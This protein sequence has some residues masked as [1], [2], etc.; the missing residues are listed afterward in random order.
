MALL[1]DVEIKEAIKNSEI[2]IDPFDER[3]LKGSS[4]DLRIGKK[5]IVSRSITLEELRGKIQKEAIKEVSIE[6][7]ESVSIPGG[8]F[9]LISTLERIKLSKMQAGHIGMR[10]YYVRKGLAL[11]SGLQI[12]PGWDGNLILGLA[13]LSPR[14][15]TLDYKDELCTIEIHRLN[16]EVGK[17]YNG[18][19]MA[20]QREGRIPTADKD[21]L[22]TI[23]T[24][25]VTDLT[26]ALIDLSSSVEGIGK[27]FRG[28]WVGIGVVVLIAVLSFILQLTQ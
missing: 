26:K 1:T 18:V 17:V 5:G 7:E 12:D 23:E 2:E 9:A 10:S 8:S 14:T 27:Q 11:L 20:D 21:Y 24:M 19:Y 6:K 28:F 3:Y 16:R 22:R 25:S 15:I 4:Y 13:N